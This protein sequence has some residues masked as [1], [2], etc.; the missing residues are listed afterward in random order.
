MFFVH[1]P[2]TMMYSTLLV[3]H[4]LFRWLVLL[5]LLYSMYRAYR[6]L[7]RK[8]TFTKTDDRWRHWTATI[9]HIQLVTGFTIYLKSPVVKFFFSNIREASAHL[10]TLFFGAIH[11]LFMLAAITLI[12][13]GSALAKRRQS[14]P[15]KFKTMLTWFALG[16]F[17]IFLAIPWPFS[18]L[19]NRSYFKSF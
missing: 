14:D 17:L 18:P 3:L 10:E 16:L 11:T 1:L 4:S 19:A 8:T 6:G 9:A 7:S 13:I 12:T 5:S 15:E 2:K